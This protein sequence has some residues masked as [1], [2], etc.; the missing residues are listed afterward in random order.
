MRI[1]G[2]KIARAIGDAQPMMRDRVT[3]AGQQYQ[4]RCK[5]RPMGRAILRER[6]VERCAAEHDEARL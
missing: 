6:P 5:T 1:E 2:G 3:A 4:Q